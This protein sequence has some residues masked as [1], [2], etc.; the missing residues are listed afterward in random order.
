MLR[1]SGKTEDGKSVVSGFFTMVDEKGVPLTIVLDYLNENEL[2]PDWIDFLQ[3]T[4]KSNWNIKSTQ[5][6]ISQSCFEVYGSEHRD[7]VMKNI[8][9]WIT[10]NR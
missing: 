4:I 1:I 2:I 5:E 3:E 8:E 10:N 6:K 7:V 9:L